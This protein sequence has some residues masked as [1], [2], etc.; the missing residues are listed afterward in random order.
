LTEEDINKFENISLSE[1]SLF[2][3]HVEIFKTV[4]DD[5]MVVVFE[6]DAVLHKKFINCLQSCLSD[7]ENEEWD[8]LFCGECVNLHSNPE[9]GKRVCK[10]DGSRG[11]CMYVLNAGVAKRLYDIFLNQSKIRD[12]IDWWFNNIEKNTGNKLRYYWSEPTLVLQGSEIGMFSSA[13]DRT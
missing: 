3:K 11:P 8:V 5:E 12:Q 6:D 7:L 10:S 9:Y 13:I 1:L 2:L 4:P